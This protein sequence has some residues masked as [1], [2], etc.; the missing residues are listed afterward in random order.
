MTVRGVVHDPAGSPVEH[1]RVWT[2]GQNDRIPARATQAQDL[3]LWMEGLP[4]TAVIEGD[5]RQLS[6]FTDAEGRFTCGGIVPTRKSITLHA[7]RGGLGSGSTPVTLSSPTGAEQEVVITLEDDRTRGATIVG[8]LTFN[9]KPSRGT[10]RWHGPT[11]AGEVNANIRGDFEIIGLENGRIRLDPVPEAVLGFE[12]RGDPGIPLRSWS[13]QCTKGSAA[14]ADLDVVLAMATISGRVRTAGGE[15]LSRYNVIL[16]R[17]VRDGGRLVAVGGRRSSTTATDGSYQIKVPRTNDTYRLTV[18][19]NVTWKPHIRE[20]VHPDDCDVDVV[21]V[22]NEDS[23]LSVRGV[24]AVTH[25][26]VH[27]VDLWWRKSGENEDVGSHID[28]GSTDQDDRTMV[29]LPPGV[30]DILARS[31]D[32]RFAPK[33]VLG[34]RAINGSEPTKLDIEMEPGVEI[35]FERAPDSPELPAGAAIFLI[36]DADVSNV[37]ITRDARGEAS[38]TG[39]TWLRGP[40]IADRQLHFDEKGSWRVRCLRPGLYRW[41]SATPTVVVEPAVV[42]VATEQTGPIVIRTLVR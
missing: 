15:G 38:L 8:R 7:A 27:P 12:E 14:Q 20:G 23:R 2:D 17:N 10:I 5:Y 35:E 16:D 29:A 1:A 6:S 19:D 26:T 37:H 9:G 32:K 34:V 41:V 18:A 33:L 13:I 4:D 24:S 22:P 39:S 21:I 25:E 40:S 42:S 3:P 30:Y 28:F 31:D 11:Q 36:E